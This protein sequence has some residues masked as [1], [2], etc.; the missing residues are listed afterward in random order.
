MTICEK[1]QESGRYWTRHEFGAYCQKIYTPNFLPLYKL[2]E[3]ADNDIEIVEDN[4]CF[5]NSH[6]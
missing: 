1:G 3:R 4:Y 2:L 5:H 6:H